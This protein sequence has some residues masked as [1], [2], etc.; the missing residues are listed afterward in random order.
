MMKK[1]R[2]KIIKYKVYITRMGSY[3]NVV[4]SIMLVFSILLGL[5]VYGIDINIMQN[6]IIAIPLVLLM[7]FVGGYIEYHFFYKTELKYTHGMNPKFKE[8]L[9]ELEEIKQKLNE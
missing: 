2:N 5:N 8:I 6:L 4:N 3:L 1:L 9:D 7:V